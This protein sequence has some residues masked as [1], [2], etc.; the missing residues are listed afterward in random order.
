MDET[1][2]ILSSDTIVEHPFLRV[3]MDAVKLPDGTVIPDWPT[4]YAKDYINVMVVD[5]IGRILVLEGYRHGSRRHCWQTIGGYLEEGEAP[6]AAAQRELLEEAGLVCEHWRHLSSFVVDANRYVGT[7]HFFLASAPRSVAD[8]ASGDL[9]TYSLN[10]VDAAEVRRA[11]LDG[12]INIMSY[13]INFSLG[14]LVLDE[15]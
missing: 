11:L 12:R 6:L 2:E 14:L 5:D 3:T 8:P 15:G 9:E 4:V 10:W 13:G 1:W 7:G